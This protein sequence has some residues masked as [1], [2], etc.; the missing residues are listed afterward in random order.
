MG[1]LRCSRRMAP[2][3]KSATTAFGLLLAVLLLWPPT[4]VAA[5]SRTA[6]LDGA[7]PNQG[8]AG[9]ST[10]PHDRPAE[11]PAATNGS[12][13]WSRLTSLP[14]TLTGFSMTYDAADHYVLLF[15]G[16]GSGGYP[17]NST[18]TYANGSWTNITALEAT[19][20]SPRYGMELAYDSG[21]GYVLGYGGITTTSC[22]SDIYCNDTWEFVHGQWTEIHPQC[23]FP[24]LGIRSCTTYPGLPVS[25]GSPETLVD[26]PNQ[27]YVLFYTCGACITPDGGSDWTYHNGIWTDFVYNY[28]TNQTYY[29]PTMAALAYDSADGYVLGFGGGGG[30]PLY[31]FGGW[32]NVTYRWSNET[33]TNESR[34][35]SVSPA[36]RFAEALAS[37][38]SSG[39]I[40]LYG[41]WD[42]VCQQFAGSSCSQGDSYYLNDT[43]EYLN[44]SW[45]QWTTQA[46]PGH[47]ISDAVGDSSDGGVLLVGGTTCTANCTGQPSTT[48][49]TWLWSPYPPLAALSIQV[50]PPTVDAGFPVRFMATYLGGTPPTTVQWNFGD[51]TTSAGSDVTHTFS[52]AGTHAV[53]VWVNDSANH[54]LKGQLSILVTATLA[55]SPTASPNPVDVGF[56]TQLSAGESGGVPPIHYDWS[57]GDGVTIGLNYSPISHIYGSKGSYTVVLNATDSVGA[58]TTASIQV[59]VNP[60]PKIV[61]LNAT[62]SSVVLGRPV[63]FT[64]TVTGGTLPYTYAW[65]FGDGGT[66]GNLSNITHIYTTNGPFV[67]TL[68]VTDAGGATVSGS[69]NVSVA[70]NA[71][72][73]SNGSLGAA[74]LL[75]VFQANATGG[76]PSYSYLWDFGDGVQSTLS[77]PMHTFSSAGAYDVILEVHDQAGHSALA[78][79]QI[80][81][82]PGGGAL[83]LAIGVSRTSLHVGETTNVSALAQGG[84]GLY[85]LTWTSVP[86]GCRVASGVTLQCTAGENGTFSVSA[87]LVDSR[88]AI[89]TASGSFT[90]GTLPGGPGVGTSS[91]WG[92]PWVLGIIFAIV[93]AAAIGGGVYA[94]RRRRPPRTGPPVPTDDRYAAYRA[95]LGSPRQPPPSSGLDPLDDIF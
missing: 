12:P 9:L 91:L 83:S 71:S 79:R 11:S 86:T 81:V 28:S 32:G 57:F 13:F 48:N 47:L 40:L 63:N 4:G 26:V 59:T 49:E 88:G 17:T 75:L 44:G 43:W 34:N 18:W 36:P 69:L 76:V 5:V 29:A 82:F 68:T 95:P 42:F 67:A 61:T 21:D 14:V 77:D 8:G 2:G 54:A 24:G 16:L 72:V 84:Y 74:P 73:F 7:P 3:Q 92:Y 33:W 30:Q 66:G 78:A 31:D 10:S 80:H 60:A 93:G 45:S 37:D 62:P 23:D 85:T 15:G 53:A 89:A 27:N 25:A 1:G 94:I 35:L 58:T 50:V 20:P 22:G 56:P 70:L 51:A 87:T 65:S 90:V 39:G 46:L 6:T 19:S 55:L 41:G 38:P 52:S 64:T